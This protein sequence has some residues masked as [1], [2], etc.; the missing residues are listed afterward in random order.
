MM[1]CTVHVTDVHT[2]GSDREENSF[3]AKGMIKDAGD[4][5]QICYFENSGDGAG[6]KCTVTVSDENK[7]RVDRGPNVMLMEKDVR[8]VCEYQTPYGVFDLGITASRILW[9]KT[10]KTVSLDMTYR[11]DSA[12]SDAGRTRIKITA[13]IEEA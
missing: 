9:E 12:G 1:R 3:D 7:V 4:E 10:E 5:C 13:E 2:D 6:I 8:T 11:I